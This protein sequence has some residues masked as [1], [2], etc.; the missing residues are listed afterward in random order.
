M[1][2]KGER[3]T[4]NASYLGGVTVERNAPTPM[5]DG[6]VLR[7]DVYRPEAAG[8]Y[9][10]LI[11][12]TPYDK[13]VAQQ[14]TYQHPSWYARRGF[15]VVVQDTRG[16]VA[17]DGDFRP[18]HDEAADTADTIRWA[19]GLAGTNGKVATYGFSYAG[20]N[21]LL[22]AAEQPDALRCIAPGFTGSDLYD[23]WTYVG[24]AFSLAFIISWVQPLLAL[25]DALKRGDVKAAIALA[26]R[27]ND[28]PDLYSTQPLQDF[29]LFK[30]ADVADYFFDWLEHDTRDSF[31]RAL[32][33]RDRY[34]RILAP[35]LHVGGWYDTFIEG[36]LENYAGLTERRA[37]IPLDC[38]VSSW[39]HGCISRG[40]RSP[41][42]ATSGTTRGTWSTSSRPRGSTT[43]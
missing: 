13:T 17:S 12:R 1:S 9:P 3:L 21:Q 33:I 16:R 19:S 35:A 36:T 5:R 27:A 18:F 28:F 20:A 30:D 24:G 25:P 38:S 34:E 26:S 43:G 2:A 7:A 14:I 40:H 23:G 37:A 42:S 41:A 6:V 32:S 39:A 22:G 15:V 29:P 4:S 10:V 11:Q 31:W 8:S